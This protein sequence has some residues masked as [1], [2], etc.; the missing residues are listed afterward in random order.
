MWLRKRG[1]SEGDVDELGA[2]LIEGDSEG[3]VDG[4]SVGLLL[5]GFIDGY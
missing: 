1:S 4:A 5:L 2:E 3:F